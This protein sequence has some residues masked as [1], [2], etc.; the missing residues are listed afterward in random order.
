MCWAFAAWP[1][2]AGKPLAPAE[3]T[4]QTQANVQAAIVFILRFSFVRVCG[5]PDADLCH[6]M[7][8][9]ILDRKG[10]LQQWCGLASGL[11]LN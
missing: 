8:G 2:H 9:Q 6:W 5:E 3:A 7:A 1:R 10:A 4:M 11:C